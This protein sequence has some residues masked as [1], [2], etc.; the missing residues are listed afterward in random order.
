V[1][2]ERYR[3]E[4]G[5]ALRWT[6]VRAYDALDVT[7]KRPVVMWKIRARRDSIEQWAATHSRAVNIRHSNLVAVLDLAYRNSVAFSESGGPEP[8][9]DVTVVLER[10]DQATLSELMA[11]RGLPPSPAGARAVV[12]QLAEAL[13]VVHGHGLVHGAVDPAHIR[14][15]AGDERL[16]ARLDGLVVQSALS[17]RWPRGPGTAVPMSWPSPE[18][19]RGEALPPTDVYALGCLTYLLLT[20]RAPIGRWTEH[21]WRESEGHRV[22][23]LAYD[24]PSA[25]IEHPAVAP[26]VAKVIE[27]ALEPDP[28]LRPPVADY[29]AAVLAALPA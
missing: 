15:S 25:R 9:A 22:V 10:V 13:T 8:V 11:Q 16:E 2:G 24:P 1:E 20:G 6:S 3:T 14:L 7:S 19:L 18:G 27:R 28:A 12:A 26:A 23:D 5:R 21:G 4:R 29:A 17:R